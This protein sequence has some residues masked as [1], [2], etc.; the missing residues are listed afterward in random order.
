MALEDISGAVR[1][2]PLAEDDA[3]DLDP[4]APV[5]HID[6][7]HRVLKDAEAPTAGRESESDAAETVEQPTV[8]FEAPPSL[9]DGE[10]RDVLGKDLGDIKRL[11]EV[12]GDEV[13]G[14]G[15]DLTFH[16]RSLQHGIYIPVERIIAFA[17][18]VFAELA[19]PFQRKL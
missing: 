1:G 12:K 10:V 2:E 7:Q 15:W 3:Q 11:A 4:G 14:Y 19:L 16:Q 5:L 18:H 8:I 17:F 6:P 13:A 9:T